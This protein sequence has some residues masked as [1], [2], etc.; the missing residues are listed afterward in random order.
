M[1]PNTDQ[2]WVG[3]LSMGMVIARNWL[4]QGQPA[5]AMLVLEEVLHRFSLSPVMDDELRTQLA[6]YW[7]GEENDDDDRHVLRSV[8]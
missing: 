8:R 6:E 4:K 1:S 7:I 5:Q 2:Y 3:A